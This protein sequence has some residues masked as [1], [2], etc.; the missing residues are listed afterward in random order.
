MAKQGMS[1]LRKIKWNRDNIYNNPVYIP[2][3]VIRWLLI[4]PTY[5][6]Q[7]NMNDFAYKRYTFKT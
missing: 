1:E 6:M 5:D 2:Y 7:C 3:V 4:T